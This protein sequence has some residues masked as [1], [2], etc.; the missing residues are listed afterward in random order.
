MY[1]ICVIT[2]RLIIICTVT[3][4]SC[5]IS[6]T[7]RKLST[8]ISQPTIFEQQVSLTLWEITVTSQR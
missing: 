2:Y 5:C 8:V 3:Q 7:P 4:M 6:L 1:S